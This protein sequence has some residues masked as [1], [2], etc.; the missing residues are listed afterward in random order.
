MKYSAKH[1]RWKGGYWECTLE[2]WTACQCNSES[3][4][5]LI[6]QEKRPS[7]TQIKDCAIWI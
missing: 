6:Y 5:V 2:R 4:K 1:L 3:T 7:L